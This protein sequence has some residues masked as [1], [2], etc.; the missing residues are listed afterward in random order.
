MDEVLTL[1]SLHDIDGDLEGRKAASSESDLLFNSS[2][3]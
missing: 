3:I 2:C 1:E